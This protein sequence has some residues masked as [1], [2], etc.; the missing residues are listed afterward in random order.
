LEGWALDLFGSRIL[1]RIWTILPRFII[2]NTWKER[3]NRV[4]RNKE[5]SKAEIWQR[6]MGNAIESI[7]ATKWNSKDKKVSAQELKILN[8]W[9]V[10]V[11]K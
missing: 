8:E 9:Q 7:K 1:Y 5:C 11:L 10:D 3:N 2:W 4:F 6:I